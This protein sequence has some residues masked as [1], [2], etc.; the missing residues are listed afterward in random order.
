MIKTDNLRQYLAKRRWLKCGQAIRA[1]NRLSGEIAI[2]K[3]K[4][5]EV[6]KANDENLV[7]RVKDG[8]D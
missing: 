6:A 3:M 8:D 4:S 1:V 7:D 5:F 2:N